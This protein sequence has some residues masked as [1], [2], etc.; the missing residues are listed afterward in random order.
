MFTEL[1]AF[2][3]PG[4]VELLV[5]GII[6]VGAVVFTVLP[7]WLVFEKAGFPG[8]LALLMLLPVVN[9]AMLFFLAFADWPALRRP[10]A[11][12]RLP[13]HDASERLD[14]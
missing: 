2:A 11:A 3:M 6:A 1:S 5:I 12:G 10:A 14:L 7:F 8:A 13:D 9:V 4:F